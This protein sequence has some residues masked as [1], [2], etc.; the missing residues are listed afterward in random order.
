MHCRYFS[1]DIRVRGASVALQRRGIRHSTAQYNDTGVR[2]EG[3]SL[4]NQQQRLT[5][6]TH[7]DCPD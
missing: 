6:I 4:S 3:E 1:G 5:S 7:H 2:P